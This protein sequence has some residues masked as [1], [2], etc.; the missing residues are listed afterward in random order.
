VA[1]HKASDY[2][3]AAQNIQTTVPKTMTAYTQTTQL[4]VCYIL[5]GSLAL[6]ALLNQH[7]T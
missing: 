1:K 5:S 7:M 2:H 6:Q 4:A 3:Q